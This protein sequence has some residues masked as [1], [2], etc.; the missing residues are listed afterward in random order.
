L[1][2]IE[3]EMEEGLFQGIR[4]VVLQFGSHFSLVLVQGSIQRNVHGV[5]NGLLPSRVL[6]GDRAKNKG[7]EAGQKER[8]HLHV[9]GFRMMEF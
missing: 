1:E 2:S 6:S 5:V 7:R 4:T 9:E 8:T 3:E